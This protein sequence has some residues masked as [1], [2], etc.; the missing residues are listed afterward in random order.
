MRDILAGRQR[1]VLRQ[2]AWS[3]VL[4][5]FDYDGTLAPIV[6]DPARA[7]M[8]PGT[9]QLLGEVAALYPCIVVS[10][11]SRAD[12]R[13]WLQGIPLRQVVGN[14]GIEP[15]QANTPVMDEVR[16][17]TPL[18]HRRLD[19]F[20][21]VW[22]EDKT[23]SIAVHYRHSREKKKVRA[24]ILEAAG[25]LGG[26]RV[27]GGKQVVNVLPQGAPHKGMAVQ[28][29]RD[30]LGLDTVIYVGDDETDEDVFALREPGRLLSIRVGSSRTSKADYSLVDQVAMDDF[31]KALA[32]LRQG[33]RRELGS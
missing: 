19:R 3:S 6:P 1:E 9:R 26:V 21:G 31:L 16:R 24:A 27:I 23:F 32:A 22:L 8:R 2:F 7:S 29:E 15:W 18:L 20:K 4:L 5:A 12:A 25:A 28:R 14:H 30:R 33:A 13:R 10:G 17:W 11:R